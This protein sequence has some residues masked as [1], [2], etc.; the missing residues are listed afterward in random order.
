MSF[1]SLIVAAVTFLFALLASWALL[2]P[3]F[4]EE[5]L[6]EEQEDPELLDLLARKDLALQALEDLERD[7]LLRRIPE[8]DYARSKA[9]LVDDAALY[10]AKIEQLSSS[11]ALHASRPAK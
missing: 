4:K 1:A 3:F 8:N 7:F 5:V 2:M 6:R 10:V 11:A 9:E